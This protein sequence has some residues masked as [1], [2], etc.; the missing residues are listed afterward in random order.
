VETPPIQ[1]ATTIDGVN[2]AHQLRG[3]KAVDLV[4][5]LGMAGN[6]EVEFEPLWGRRF[7]ERLTSFP[8][9]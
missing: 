2:I 7:L 5:T 6:F 4:Y 3:D 8:P 1:Y 9:G